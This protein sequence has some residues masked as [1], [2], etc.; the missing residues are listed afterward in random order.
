MQRN[1]VLKTSITSIRNERRQNEQPSCSLSSFNQKPPAR[2]TDEALLQSVGCGPSGTRALEAREELK[3][4]SEQASRF[5]TYASG[6]GL[7]V[8]IGADYLFNEQYVPWERTAS[9]QPQKALARDADA[10]EHYVDSIRDRKERAESVYMEAATR[11]ATEMK[12][13]APSTQA[14]VQ[15]QHGAPDYKNNCF[16]PK[17]EGV[18]GYMDKRTELRISDRYDGLN[19][20][21]VS[22]RTMLRHPISS[23]SRSACWEKNDIPKA[24]CTVTDNKSA[25]ERRAELL[26]VSAGSQPIPR[27]VIAKTAYERL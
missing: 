1:R 12:A 17:N 26:G 9:G 5:Q 27:S 19:R 6:T 23:V 4:V 25:V 15:R 20:E 24:T 13:V 11:H 10:A 3:A 16:L 14:Y 22:H 18:R 2:F 21:P 7:Q 8:S